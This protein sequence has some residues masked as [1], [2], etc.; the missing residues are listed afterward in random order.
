MFFLLIKMDQKIDLLCLGE[1][2]E[3]S[4]KTVQNKQTISFNFSRL[5]NMSHHVW[6]RSYV[7]LNRPYPRIFMPS[8]NYSKQSIFQRY[9]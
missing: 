3:A 6:R 4:L 9:W 7:C 2:S 5:V 8:N 1:Y